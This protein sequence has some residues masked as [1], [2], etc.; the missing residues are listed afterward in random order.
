[1]R[2]LQR[3]H[4]LNVFPLGNAFLDETAQLRRQHGL[5]TLQRLGDEGVLQLL[6]WM[7]T[8]S[9]GH[10][11]QLQL[12]VAR[13]CRLGR[14]LAATGDGQIFASCRGMEGWKRIKLKLICL[15]ALFFLVFWAP[16]DWKRAIIGRQQRSACV[17]YVCT[18]FCTH[19]SLLVFWCYC[20]HRKTT[21]LMSV[22]AGYLGAKYSSK[23]FFQWK[24][25]ITKVFV[26]EPP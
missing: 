23:V 4:P 1:M 11:L 16:V 21:S 13:L 18:A 15:E 10:L 9:L 12:H 3:N 25:Y 5:G 8:T 19:M 14:T 17:L 20:R 2:R 22:M 6:R 7:D 24:S 26:L